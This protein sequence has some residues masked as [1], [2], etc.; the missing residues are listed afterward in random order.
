MTPPD[1]YQPPSEGPKWLFF[2]LLV[3]I[4]GLGYLYDDPKSPEPVPEG[5]SRM[6][7][8]SYF[9]D[10][11]NWSPKAAETGNSTSWGFINSDGTWVIPPR[12]EYA[13]SFQ[14]ELYSTTRGAGCITIAQVRFRGKWGFIDVQGRYCVPPKYDETNGFA[15]RWAAVRVGEKW[16]YINTVGEEMLAPRFDLAFPFDDMDMKNGR[17]LVSIDGAFHVIDRSGMV[18]DD[19]PMHDFAKGLMLIDMGGEFTFLDRLASEPFRERFSSAAPFFCDRAKV[20]PRGQKLFG[21][22]DG[23]GKTVIPASFV[24]AS[25]FR[26]GCAFVTDSPAWNAD[27]QYH[28]IDVSGNDACPPIPRKNIRKGPMPVKIG[29]LW[30]YVD[31]TRGMV[32]QPR[33]EQAGGFSNGQALV[34]GW[35]GEEGG[36]AIW[37][38]IDEN[39]NYLYETKPLAESPDTSPSPSPRK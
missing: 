24:E 38:M 37:F 16:G 36:Q 15:D 2:F 34:K 25:D 31:F 32:I 12:F 19:R 3:G 28:I 9:A 10:A 11:V 23:S 22:V 14:N 20:M 27:S 30:G 4:V 35:R 39:G 26:D 8:G 7:E 29:T 33:F 5:R 6:S 18:V 13:R 21:Y 1:F 17:A